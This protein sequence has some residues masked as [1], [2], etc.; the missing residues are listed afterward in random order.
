MTFT[1]ESFRALFD[2]QRDPLFRFLYRLTGSEAEADDLLQDTFLTVWR[3]RHLYEGRGSAAGF[4][5]KTGFRLFLNARTTRDRRGPMTPIHDIDS[6]QSPA[7]DDAPA[8]ERSDAMDFLA[9]RVREALGAL[10]D[11]ARQA[12]VLFRFE[13]FTCGEIA[14]VTGAPLKTVESRVR[15]ATRA[16]AER[17]RPYREDVPVR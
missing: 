3:K 4:L 9:E 8:L 14:E 11:T 17:L 5:R 10:P 6:A 7:R 15:R 1:Q 16:L 13:G 2:D 12:F